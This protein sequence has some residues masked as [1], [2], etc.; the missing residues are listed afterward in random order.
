M[1]SETR[2]RLIAKSL[3]VIDERKN[4]PSHDGNH[5]LQVLKN[6]ET[7]AAIEGGDLDVLIPAALLHDVVIYAKN[8][9][10]S[11]Q[12]PAE[13]AELTKEILSGFAEYPADKIPQV[14]QVISGCSFNKQEV[15]GTL[16]GKILCDADK[17]EAT[18][19]VSIMRT[20]SSGGQMGR[21]LYNRED[22]FAEN[23]PADAKLQ[24]LDL[25]YERLLIA[26]DRLHTDTAKKIAEQRTEILHLFLEQLKKEI[27]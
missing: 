15:P 22:P 3:Q 20:F 6:V 9:P 5:A 23:R 25:F 21:P 1:T 16:E 18:G 2:A 26:K 10:R 12:A 24:S 7:I 8:D 4:D 27:V 19:A 17:L 14:M 13:S 11:D